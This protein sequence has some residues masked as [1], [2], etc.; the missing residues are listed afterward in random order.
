MAKIAVIKTGGKQYKVREGQ[1]LSIEKLPAAVGEKVNF[2]TFLLA[3]SETGES[4]IG[5]PTLGEQVE[6]KVVEQ[7]KD[8]KVLVVKFHNKVR[9]KRTNGHRQNLT[10]VEITKIA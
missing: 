8:D 10:K 2:E 1:V 6:G 3:D 9:Y 4:T 7:F 5:K